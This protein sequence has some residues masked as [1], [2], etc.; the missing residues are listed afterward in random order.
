MSASGVLLRKKSL[1]ARAGR[2]GLATSGADVLFRSCEDVAVLHF[3]F[4]SSRPP[5]S[6]RL[7]IDFASQAAGGI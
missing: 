6:R 5:V 3:G 4:A 7:G 1:S 2:D